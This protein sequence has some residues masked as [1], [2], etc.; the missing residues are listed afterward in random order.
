VIIDG[1]EFHDHYEIDQN[2]SGGPLRPL[3]EACVNTVEF[4]EWRKDYLHEAALQ[5][6]S[7]EYKEKLAALEAKYEEKLDAL[8][9]KLDAYQSVH[10]ELLRERTEYKE[11]L[12]A[13]QAKLDAYEEMF[14]GEKKEGTSE[15]PPPGWQMRDINIPELENKPTNQPSQD[16]QMPWG[17]PPNTAP[18]KGGGD[19]I[20]TVL[21]GK[22]GQPDMILTPHGWTQQGST[23]GDYLSTMENSGNPYATESSSPAVLLDLAKSDEVKRVQQRLIELGYLDGAAD[24][25]WGPRSRHA[26]QQFRTAMAIGGGDYWDQQ[27]QQQLFSRL[28]TSQTF[29]G[30]WGTDANQCRQMQR[31]RTSIN[32][33]RAEAFGAVCEF[34][35]THR[36]SSNA[37][38]FQATCSQ[39]G[40]RWDA[41]IRLS[42][43]G[44]TLTWTSER[45]TATYLRCSGT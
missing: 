10:V 2:L 4:E 19:P 43:S 45:G 23:V 12:N 39:Q 15:T 38:R 34:N 42:I 33:R 30:S 41:N 21:R 31:G 44:N 17:P 32:G 26:L 22:N 1:D 37:W 11:K 8:Q 36:E 6:A 40:N 5:R 13:L 24:G 27:T 9:A 16:H 18:E 7:D 25:L 3:I 14:R 35:S 29:I 20:G 28:A